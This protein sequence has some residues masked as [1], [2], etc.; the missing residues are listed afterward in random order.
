MAQMLPFNIKYTNLIRL[1]A[2]LV[3]ITPVLG[4]AQSAMGTKE[5]LGE[6]KDSVQ[7][8]KNTW[9]DVEGQCGASL[10]N[11]LEM[12]LQSASQAA[13]IIPDVPIDLLAEARVTRDQWYSKLKTHYEEF[14]SKNLV[15]GIEGIEDFQIHAL[16]IA[17]AATSGVG[18]TTQKG[19]NGSE[20]STAGANAQSKYANAAA[21]MRA[22]AR[23]ADQGHAGAKELSE[24]ATNAQSASVTQAQKLQSIV[25]DIAA[26]Q[27]QC[28][29]ALSGFVESLEKNRIAFAVYSFDA[30]IDA[31][32][33]ET[34][35][36]INS[37]MILNTAQAINGSSTTAPASSPETAKGS[38][39]SGGQV[40]A[41]GVGALAVGGV[42]GYFLGKG[43]SKGDSKKS[44]AAPSAPQSSP[45][46]NAA[47][48]PAT[49]AA[50]SSKTTQ[51]NS[52][53]PPPAIVASS[54]RPVGPIAVTNKSI[55]T[56]APSRIAQK[57]RTRVMSDSLLD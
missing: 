34:Q 27:A 43:S 7:P 9:I 44:E 33:F 45:V 16:H 48:S 18:Q 42:A 52:S 35:S 55:A 53:Q 49:P 2:T 14:L 20:M 17:T 37:G 51:S 4:F 24:E 22:A 1:A 40:A 57:H 6:L 23:Q 32:G 54:V 29:Q 46:A 10:Q 3:A 26:M 56:R 21:S 15:T 28:A 47:A 39:L 12:K 11:A 19:L 50:D 36:K 25:S 38:G 30:E 41:I 13:Q 8:V 31:I 5:S